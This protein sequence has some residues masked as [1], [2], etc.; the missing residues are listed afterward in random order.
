MWKVFYG[1]LEKELSEIIWI[2]EIGS[3]FFFSFYNGMPCSNGPDAFK[4]KPRIVFKVVIHVWLN[5]A[6]GGTHADWSFKRCAEV[7]LSFLE[8]AIM[9]QI[10]GAP[11]TDQ[12][13]MVVLIK[14]H[15]FEFILYFPPNRAPNGEPQLAKF[16]PN[17]T[18]FRMC[19]RN[20]TLISHDRIKSTRIFKSIEVFGFW[21]S[22]VFTVIKRFRHERDI[23]HFSNNHW[24]NS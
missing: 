22:E 6:T 21:F 16:V 18:Q 14:T 19:Y 11:F 1:I 13:P 12:D 2:A 10:L 8:R 15:T 23:L 4:A 5:W 17:L 20:D 3:D 7:G 9:S 24:K